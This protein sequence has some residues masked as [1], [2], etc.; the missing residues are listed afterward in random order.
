MILNPLS[1]EE[2]RELKDLNRRERW[3]MAPLLGLI[4]LIGV[5]PQPFLDRMSA[6]VDALIERVELPARQM[7][8]AKASTERNGP[9]AEPGE[10]ERF[11]ATP[12][13]EEA[14][15]VQWSPGP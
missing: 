12:L 13:A 10:A 11:D 7:Q 1:S 4:L 3:I 9:I 8:A 15:Q 5:Y 6:S 2:N 14:T